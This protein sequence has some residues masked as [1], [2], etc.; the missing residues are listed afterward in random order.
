MKLRVKIEEL[1]LSKKL[2]DVDCQKLWDELLKK[3]A[4]VILLMSKEQG[5]EREIEDMQKKLVKIETE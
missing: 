1:E 3:D 5:K 4:E 2:V